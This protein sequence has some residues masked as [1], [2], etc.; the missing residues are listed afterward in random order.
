MKVRNIRYYLE[1]LDFDKD[2]S[3]P[4]AGNKKVIQEPSQA[5]NTQTLYTHTVGQ[6]SSEVQMG[7]QCHV[8][9]EKQWGLLSAL[10]MPLGL[11]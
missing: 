8:Y 9:V 5:L 3:E 1:Y 2:S 4:I 11:V 10:N 6:R 7:E